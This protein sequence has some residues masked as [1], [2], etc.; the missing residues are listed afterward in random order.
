MD[1]FLGIDVGTSG[2]RVILVTPDGRVVAEGAQPLES[3]R[4]PGIHEQDPEMWWT[5]VAQLI[6]GLAIDAAAIQS[7]AVTST[8]GSL[9]LTDENGNPVRNAILYDDARAAS[10]LEPFREAGCDDVNASWSLAKAVWVRGFESTVWRRVVH[11]LHPAD[12]LAGKLTGLWN[13]S[14]YS[15]SLKLGYDPVQQHWGRAAFVAQMDPAVLPEVL[16]PG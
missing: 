1:L 7:V 4:Q 9:V 16:T 3:I 12:W 11:L 15:N 6:R 5:A 13:V 8:S 2:A 10:V 14:D